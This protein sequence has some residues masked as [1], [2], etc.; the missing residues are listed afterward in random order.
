[1]DNPGWFGPPDRSL[2]GWLCTPQDGNAFLGVVIC[3]PIGEEEH[4]AHETFR[5]LAWSLA[6]HGIASLRFDYHGTGDSLGRW[7]DPDRLDAW[8]TSVT[9]AVR[10]LKEAGA[11]AV[12]V[13]GMRV[14]AT[15]A[16]VAAHQGRIEIDGLLLWDPVSGKGMLR[17]GQAR[18]PSVLEPPAGAVD[19][20]GYL[21]SAPTAAELRSLDVAT[22]GPGPIAPQLLVV[23]RED[24]PAPRG[25]RKRLAGPDVEWAVTDEQPDLL[26]VPMTE[27]AVPEKTLARVVDWLV[28]RSTGH[29]QKISQVLTPT[30]TFR[31]DIGVR[32]S[33]RVVAL[34]SIGLFGILSEP[35]AVN[36]PVLVVMI[37]VANDRHTGPGRRWVDSSREWAN[38]GFRVLRM[39]QSGT[40]DSPTHEGQQF[41]T[42]YAREWLADLPDALS[43]PMLQHSPLVLI[44]LCSGAYSAM[45][46]AFYRP[47]VAVYAINV[48]LHAR[49]TSRWS[50]L[51]DPRRIAA[52]PAG[53]AFQRTGDRWPRTAALMWRIY[54]QVTVWNAPMAA[55]AALVRQGTIVILVMSPD[56]GRHFRESAFWSGLHA[57]RW[58]RSGRYALLESEQVD[59]PLMTQEGQTW[60]MRAIRGDLIRR[61]VAAPHEAHSSPADRRA[62]RKVLSEG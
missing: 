28:A 60:A 48:I 27:S 37:N 57:W 18:R 20:P 62:V 52:R 19:T 53:W 33:E 46:A 11:T 2:F 30:L 56:D 17:E 24:R 10:S 32:V 35:E 13:V 5:R 22:L 61:F 1:M 39:D 12:V 7:S 23:L 49:V 4:N 38:D 43:C 58:R 34:G 26:D 40:G 55:V 41:G 3:P 44:G 45:E 14:G 8:L 31:T 15:L 51:A 29:P 50:T 16:A 9:D 54:R 47:V 36:R 25:L 59:H 6:D 21:Y 42:L